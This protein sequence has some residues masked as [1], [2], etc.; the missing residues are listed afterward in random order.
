MICTRSA[1]L[2]YISLPSIG[3]L[4]SCSQVVPRAL[5]IAMEED[6][7]FRRSLP[8]DYLNYMGVA[9]SDKVLQHHKWGH[10]FDD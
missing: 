8:K 9:F 10:L 1:L 2:Y 5:Q 7:E 3:Y 4:I 6:V